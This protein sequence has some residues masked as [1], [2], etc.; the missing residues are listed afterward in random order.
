VHNRIAWTT[1][2]TDGR[3]GRGQALVEFALVVPLFMLLLAGM[4][5]FGMGLNA[6]IT[7]TNA[8]REGA[9]FGTVSP[10][11]TD[12]ENRARAI[13]TGLEQS[14]LTVASSCTRPVGSTPATCTLSTWQAGDSVVVQVG[15][16][17]QMIWPLAMGT[18]IHVS[19]AS[20][21]RLE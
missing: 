14:R 1:R 2:K 5:D 11:A 19:S 3:R 15:Y 6:S 8:A 7:V 18:T 17:Y 20:E 10:D 12:I 4:V 21:M 9:R 16:D 13:A